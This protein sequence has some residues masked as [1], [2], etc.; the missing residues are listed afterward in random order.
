[1]PSGPAS[2]ALTIERRVLLLL[3]WDANPAGHQ[4]HAQLL[5]L[6]LGHAGG[7]PARRPEPLLL[8]RL[9]AKGA[10][11]ALQATQARPARREGG[12]AGRARAGGASTTRSGSSKA[13]KTAD[14]AAH[15]EATLSNVSPQLANPHTSPDRTARLPA[16]PPSGLQLV[17]QLP[18]VALERLQRLHIIA[19]AEAGKAAATDAAGLALGLE[20]REAAVQ[21]PRVVVP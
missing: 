9:L 4:P 7:Q 21:P 5:L 1:M 14:S 12:Q 20:L 16:Y 19:A 3:T 17:L 11:A 18:V 8:R 6:L 15:T 10:G 2:L 13:E